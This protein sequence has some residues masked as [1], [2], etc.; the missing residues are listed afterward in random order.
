LNSHGFLGASKTG[1]DPA[2]AVAKIKSGFDADVNTSVSVDG[3]TLTVTTTLTNKTGHMFPGAHPMRR[4]L[5]R[6]IVTDG[7]GNKL[8]PATMT[9]KSSFD[10]ITNTL[11][12]LT[13]KT[14]DDSQPTTVTLVENQSDTLD[15]PGKVADLDGSAVTSQ[16]FA[17]AESGT[18]VTISATDSTVTEQTV[19]ASGKTTGL[20]FNAA[21]VEAS[22]TTNFTRIYGHE[23]GK[24]YDLDNDPNT[25][26]VFVVR[27]GF[28]SNLVDKDTRL[29][30][31]ETETYTLTYDITDR[32]GVSA[33]YK[34]YY[35]QKG[36][37]GQFIT[38]ET[39]FLNQTASDAKKHLVTEVYTKTAN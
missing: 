37:N 29:S 11:A 33:T 2:A 22:D 14:L 31:N 30:P 13:G 23:T 21:I 24:M 18:K 36:A 28:D 38:D 1:G 19:S 4:V 8:T 27:P 17:S 32:T 20:V 6:L 25:P 7:E 3:N 26:S 16:N 34:V 35:M 12:T 15:F 9:G 5:T 39:G 10:T